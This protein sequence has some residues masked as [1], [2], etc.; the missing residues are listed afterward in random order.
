MTA[1]GG[2]VV[3]VDGRPERDVARFVWRGQC[4]GEC[5]QATT[6]KALCLFEAWKTLGWAFE[7]GGGWQITEAGRAALID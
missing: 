2:L 3:A 4:I 5:A 6:E 1:S 7:V